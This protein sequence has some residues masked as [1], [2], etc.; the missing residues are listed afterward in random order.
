MATRV[1]RTT[2]LLALFAAATPVLAQDRS[3]ARIAD[4]VGRA[5]D[6]HPQ[7]TIFDDVAARVDEGVVTL[8]GRVTADYKKQDVGR[9]VARINGVRQA[10]NHISVLPSTPFDEE[11]RYRAARAIY[12]NPA[13]WSYASMPR[14]PIHIIVEHGRVTLTGV[15]ASDVERALARSL[16]TG[17]GELSVTSELRTDR[18]RFVTAGH[19][20]GARI[21]RQP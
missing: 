1:L 6:T 8:N 3:D 2:V 14:P 15:V 7:L 12:S 13:F 20:S 5:I 18:E 4:D 16:A 19:T 9:I 10:R 11:L 21:P 17:I